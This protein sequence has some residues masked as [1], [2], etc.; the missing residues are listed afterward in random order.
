MVTAIVLLNV[1]RSSIG[2]IAE[3]L[4]GIKGV[5]EVYSVGGRFDLAAIV[6]VSSNEEL[7]DVVTKEMLKHQGIQRTETMIAFRAYSKHDLESMFS[8]G[9]DKKS[10]KK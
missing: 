3:T 4:Q 10:R 7:A 9:M 2:Y 6:R 8:V 5:S 1:D